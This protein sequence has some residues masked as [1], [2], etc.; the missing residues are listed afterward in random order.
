M[1][2]VGKRFDTSACRAIAAALS[3][4]S[5]VVCLAAFFA[6][7]LGAF[8]AALGQQNSPGGYFSEPLAGEASLPSR[9]SS[10]GGSPPFPT[11]KLDR[12]EPAPGHDTTDFPVP[13]LATRVSNLE[14]AIEKLGDKPPGQKKK[15]PG[16]FSLHL[17]GHLLM[18][19][20]TFS[21]DAA[22]RQ[23]HDEQDTVGIP[24]ARLI[25]EGDGVGTMSYKIEF[26][27]VWNLVGDLY[28]TMGQLPHVGNFRIGYM[29]EPFSLEQLESPKYTVFMERSLARDVHPIIRR[30]G[31]MVF[32]ELLEQRGTWAVGLF[33]DAPGFRV[34][35]ADPFGGAFTAR[36]TYLPWYDQPSS[37][38]RLLHTAIAYSHRLASDR[39]VRFRTLPGS[40]FAAFIIDTGEIPAHSTNLFNGELALVYGPFSVQ[41]EYSIGWIDAIGQPDS[42]VQGSYVLLSYF[43]TGENRH[44]VRSKGIFSRITPFRNFI[45]TRGESG[46]LLTGPGA[47]ELKYR[48][49]YVDAYDGGRLG[50]QQAGGHAVGVNWYLNPYSRVVAEYLYVPNSP[51]S[52]QPDGVLHIFQMRTQF[53]F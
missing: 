26:D 32:D 23:R 17:R 25:A 9:D 14:A 15:S 28:L 49:S 39:T 1:V 33:S 12:S 35:R 53:E 8:S 31:A 6:A 51:N 7:E 3:R 10:W 34:V 38:R 11:Q 42:K 19:A 52:G 37:G 22:D 13:D 43:L 41:S 40:H 47:W 20:V 27:Y 46:R 21:Q 36:T 45:R 50:A 2:A 29:K 30:M 16:G 18:D 4:R 5:R 44:Y 48:Y 24:V